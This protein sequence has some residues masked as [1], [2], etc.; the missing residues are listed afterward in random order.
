M[1]VWCAGCRRHEVWTA[2]QLG[3]GQKLEVALARALLAQWSKR[4]EPVRPRLRPPP[5]CGHS[6]DLRE[7]L[8]PRSPP[9]P[10]IQA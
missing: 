5:R 2:R 8:F 10:D 7:R 1:V 6:E 4:A 3:S 9:E